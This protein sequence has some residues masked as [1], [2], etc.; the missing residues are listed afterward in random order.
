MNELPIVQGS[1]Q[2][3]TLF[4]SHGEAVRER[5]GPRGEEG[6]MEG[7]LPGRNCLWIKDGETATVGLAARDLQPPGEVR[8]S[9][10]KESCMWPGR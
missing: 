2:V 10:A 3:K 5:K 6:A 7:V 1:R 8:G 9:L 4:I